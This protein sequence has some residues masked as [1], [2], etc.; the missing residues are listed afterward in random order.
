MIES[1]I[2]EA[3]ESDLASIAELAN[4]IWC[5]HYPGIILQEQIDYM[6]RKMYSL[7]TLRAEIRS[8]I[9]Y[10]R[11]LEEDQIVG[12]ASYGPVD[13]ASVFKLHKLYV[14]PDWHGRGLGSRL[15]QYCECEIRK[16]GGQ[17][18]ILTVNKRNLK[19][20]SFYE[21]QEF[22][23]A[24]SVVVD[25]GGGFVMDDYIMDKELT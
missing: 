2:V 23:I 6:L 25:I 20:I 12:F 9:A 5:V 17:Q 10:Q 14:H 21:K 4:I 8:G 11:V 16:N 22:K 13:R 1:R 18:L 24:D 15:L 19:A 3:K 7:E